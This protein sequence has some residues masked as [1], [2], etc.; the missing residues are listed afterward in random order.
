MK[1]AD[2][3][4]RKLSGQLKE[5]NRSLELLI[6]SGLTTASQST[7][8]LLE[9][10]IQ[11]ANSLR[12]LRLG[13]TL[14]AT[15]D[16]LG[17][18]LA[19]SSDFSRKRLCFFLTRSWL[20]SQGLLRAMREN[21]EAEFTRLLRAHS[22][23]LV[24]QVQVVTVGVARKVVVGSFC[25][26]D[27]RLRDLESGARYVWS[28]IRQLPH[29]A[30][31]PPEGYLQLPQPQRFK[32]IE[33]LE[34]CVIILSQVAITQD[35]WG[36]G[37]IRLVEKSTIQSRLPFND[38]KRFATTDWNA[39]LQRLQSYQPGPLDMEVDLQEEIVLHEWQI[40]QPFAEESQ[41]IYPIRSRQA[42]FH[43]AVNPGLDGAPLQAALDS[44]GAGVQRSPLLGLLHYERCR[45][46]LQ[47]L[48]ILEPKGPNY[49]MLS[50][51]KVSMAALLKGMKF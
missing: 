41:K 1:L 42:V 24:E 40:E 30:R 46:M 17:K 23:Q 28:H 8:K 43:V 33:F 11:E 51:E 19:N 20:L 27:F 21:D 3:E 34:G 10:S 39:V 5:L 45:L 6:N 22:E 13:A 29:D 47:P 9:V 38:W 18:F 26:F 44:L 7:R 37:R 25:S 35:E 32:P 49:L 2:A 16:E 50:K 48:A 12:L 15:N 4:S 36:L 14:R 31:V